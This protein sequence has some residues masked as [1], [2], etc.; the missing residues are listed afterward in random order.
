MHGQ[1]SR[2]RLQPLWQGPCEVVDKA[3]QKEQLLPVL[4]GAVGLQHAHCALHF[5][6][7]RMILWHEFP[8]QGIQLL[9]VSLQADIISSP[10]L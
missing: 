3:P 8:R 2:S 5:L 7:Q 6:V 9:N 4:H 10:S 1:G